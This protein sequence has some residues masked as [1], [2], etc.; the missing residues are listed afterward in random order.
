MAD[1]PFN[2]YDNSGYWKVKYY[3]ASGRRRTK[4]LGSITKLSRRKAKVLAQRFIATVH[5]RPGLV[6]AT[7]TPR[8]K[9]YLEAYTA[10]RTDL[11]ASSLKLL[12]ITARYLQ[13]F[14]GDECRIDRVTRPMA[15]SWKAALAR[16]E[17]EDCRLSL[18]P[19]RNL[20]E[21]TVYNHVVRACTMFNEAVRQD[22]IPFNPFDRLRRTPRKK[23][24]TWR[25]V[26]L[27]EL[28]LLL[29]ACPNIGWQSL[30]G[31]CRLA[32]LRRGEALGLAW[33]SVDWEQKTM[34]VMAGKTGAKRV[35][36]MVQRLQHVLLDAFGQADERELLVVSRQ[37]VSRNNL[38]R[39]FHVIIRK[40]GLEP[41]PECFQ[42]LR[43]NCATDWA[44]QVPAFVSA[45]WL[46]HSEQVEREHYLQVLKHY[47]EQVASP[48]SAPVG[49]RQQ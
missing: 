32:G 26:D 42:V 24:K 8:L 37:S 6:S 11:Q 45:A 9:V 2:L 41:W 31:L 28:E 36:P 27:D 15:A 48:P 13:G 21:R 35:V 4:S 44:G 1:T 14:F 7:E 34:S 39:N 47:H 18:S 12:D 10:G 20:S 30:I 49:C 19:A 23:D 25:Y 33:S 22:L 38:G 3:D 46:G 40:A 16:G 5:A 17:L 29:T 43:R